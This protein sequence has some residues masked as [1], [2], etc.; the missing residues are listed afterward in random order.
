MMKNLEG[1]ATERESTARTQPATRSS[2][3]PQLSRSK[4]VP[5]LRETL[6]GLSYE[7]GTARLRPRSET[8]PLHPP[9]ATQADGSE[10]EHS[11]GEAAA[12]EPS[13]SALP[14]IPVALPTVGEFKARSALPLRRRV[15]VSKIDAAL[16]ACHT[17]G[18]ARGQLK[19]V[20]ALIDAC[21]AYASLPKARRATEVFNLKNQAVAL[22]S[23]LL[24]VV[25]PPAQDLARID[26]L[27]AQSSGVLGPVLSE[28][29]SAAK[30][31]G[32]GEIRAVKAMAH[33]ARR[34]DD[35][36]QMTGQDVNYIGHDPDER[37][38]VANLVHELTHVRVQQAFGRDYVNYTNP[39][40]S[41]GTLPS[42]QIEGGRIRN[43]AERQAGQRDE[44]AEQV[45]SGKL[46]NLSALAQKDEHL[47]AEQQAE[48]VTKLAYGTQTPYLEYD[49]VLNQILVWCHYW[50][51][52]ANSPFRKELERVCAE[53]HADRQAGQRLVPAP[54]K[55]SGGDDG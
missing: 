15:R 3:Q 45:L 5:D 54:S 51:I 9:P 47:S 32:S 7:E 27:A 31:L 28:V 33:A 19:A 26:G 6:R 24:Q 10:K 44:A 30:Q 21:V 4:S 12:I 48:V 40:T 29:A 43:E 14:K 1:N 35:L 50:K 37:V 18:D 55:T 41:G 25:Y 8:G 46:T 52:H 38:R 49:T 53:A 42:P 23:E 39:S 34:Y 20:K 36:D 11:G 16:A 13:S 2:S 22:E 17:A